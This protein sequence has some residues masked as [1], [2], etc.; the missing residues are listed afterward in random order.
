MTFEENQ[1]SSIR[2]LMGTK[3]RLKALKV[4]P[5][6]SYDELLNQLMDEKEGKERGL[7]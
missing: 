4:H 5:N 6:Q 7:L 1:E 3:E 2:V